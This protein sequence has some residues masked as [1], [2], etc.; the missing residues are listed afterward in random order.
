MVESLSSQK[1]SLRAVAISRLALGN[2]GVDWSKF[3][4][5]R[6]LRLPSVEGNAQQV[7]RKHAP[8]QSVFC[9]PHSAYAETTNSFP[10]PFHGPPDFGAPGR[11]DQEFGP[12]WTHPAAY[13]VPS[14][15]GQNIWL[16]LETIRMTSYSHDGDLLSELRGLQVRVSRFRLHSEVCP[17]QLLNQTR[18]FLLSAP[19]LERLKGLF[20]GYITGSPRP[21]FDVVNVLDVHGPT[22]K[23][24]IFGH[25]LTNITSLVF[26]TCSLED[27]TD[28]CPR[29]EYLP[30]AVNWKRLKGMVKL[31]VHSG[32]SS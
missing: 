26:R 28:R 30:L 4:E 23:T 9:R 14:K 15:T 13:F 22:L 21:V 31:N 10:S 17:Q 25:R 24:S 20:E 29:L 32:G 8:R 16:R 19:R 27:V 1:D 3:L 18:D 11:Q 5:L 2:Q 12:P 6:D 7:L